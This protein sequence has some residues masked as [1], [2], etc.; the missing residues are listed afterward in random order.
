MYRTRVGVDLVKE[1]IQVCIYRNKKVQSN[2]EMT[3][4]EF[5]CWLVNQKTLTI[6]FEACGTSNYWR[7]KS[8]EAGHYARLISAKLVSVVRQ[9]QKTD[10]NDAQAIVQAASACIGLT[11]MQHSSGGLIKL[12][13]IGKHYKNSL[14]RSQ[15][16]CGAMAAVTQAV[17]REAKKRCLD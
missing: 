2:I 15:L 1:V 12:G 4:A 9:N 16:I 14:L 17:N 5:L 11:P 10:K 3:P 6:I 13:S 8:I 7:Q